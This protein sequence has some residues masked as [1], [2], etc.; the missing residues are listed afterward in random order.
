[1]VTGEIEI[2][3]GTKVDARMRDGNESAGILWRGIHVGEKKAARWGAVVGWEMD[4][5]E[6]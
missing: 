2:E 3:K 5:R 6:K 4:W 1:M